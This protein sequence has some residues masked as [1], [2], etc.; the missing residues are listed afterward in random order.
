MIPLRFKTDSDR[1]L[2]RGLHLQFGFYPRN[3]AL[4]QLAF[5]HKSMSETLVNNCRVNNER[6]EYLGDAVLSAV[7]AE[8]LFKKYPTKSE[9][10]LT[11]TRSRIVSRVSLNKLAQDI[12][13]SDFIQY[14]H[15]HSVFRSI[16]GNAFEAFVGAVFIDRGYEFT[17]KLVIN[18]VIKVY[19][20]IDEIINTDINFKSRLLEYA[21][22]NR[23][24]IKFVNVGV[25]GKGYNKRYEVEVV[26]NDKPYGRACD[27]SIKGAEQQAAEQ[28][29][30][31]L[32]MPDKE[33]YK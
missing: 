30:K 31:M 2:A 29:L 21:Q 11:E 13:L 32:N 9:G 15:G 26:M 12:G 8:Y 27:F 20:N 5:R 6:L 23:L 28:T 1:Q 33:E 16:N 25:N 18:K 24:G 4:Y 10:F 3:I 14:A 22:K 19:V 7:V 17:R